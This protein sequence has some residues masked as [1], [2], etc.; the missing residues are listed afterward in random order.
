[1]FG[2]VQGVEKVQV[3]EGVVLGSTYRVVSCDCARDKSLVDQSEW[4]GWCRCRK[5]GGKHLPP[6]RGRFYT[7]SSGQ[8]DAS[9]L[10]DF[11]TDL[12]PLAVLPLVGYLGTTLLERR[13]YAYLYLLAVAAAAFTLREVAYA[14]FNKC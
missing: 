6:E 9:E 12:I 13:P 2:Y 8:K 5:C 11:S 4:C 3:A 14:R 1:L 7:H 10:V